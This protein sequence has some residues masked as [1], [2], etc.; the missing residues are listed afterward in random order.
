M[1]CIKVHIAETTPQV[2]LSFYAAEVQEVVSAYHDSGGHKETSHELTLRYRGLIQLSMSCCA[3]L[4]FK[5]LQCQ[6]EDQQDPS[7]YPLGAK[8]C[9]DT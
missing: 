8:A 5:P 2:S 3:R 1:F 4:A 9:C 7:S 6:R